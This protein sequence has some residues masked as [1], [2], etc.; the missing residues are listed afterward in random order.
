[1]KYYLI[2][3][4]LILGAC[5]Q[6]PWSYKPEDNAEYQGIY[7]E[8]TLIADRPIRDICFEKLLMLSE[9]YTDAYAFYSEASVIISG[10][11][12]DV[13]LSPQAQKPNCFEGDASDIVQRGSVYQLRATFTWDSSG[14]NVETTY[15]ATANVPTTF[16]VND[17]ATVSE[18][19]FINQSTNV[20]ASPEGLFELV[21]GLPQEGQDAFLNEYGD[22]IGQFTNQLAEG[23]TTGAMNLFFENFQEMN[24]RIGQLYEE[25]DV[26]APY[27]QGDSIYYLT[28]GLNTTSHY[29]NFQYSDDVASVLITQRFDTN[30]VVPLN[31]FSAAFEQFGLTAATQYFDGTIR[32]LIHY[33]NFYNPGKDF[34]I[35][36]SLPV[37]NTWYMG[38]NNTIYFYGYEQAFT[39]Y[40]LTYIDEHDNP[41]VRPEFNIEGGRGVFAGAVVDSFQVFIRNPDGNR[42][43]TMF[44]AQAGYCEEEGWDSSQACQEF[45]LRYCRQTS[46]DPVKYVEENKEEFDENKAYTNCMEAAFKAAWIDSVDEDTYVSLNPNFTQSDNA[47]NAASLRTEVR[48]QALIEFCVSDFFESDLCDTIEEHAHSWKSEIVQE[49]PEVNKIKDLH[50]MYCENSSWTA[51][52]CDWAQRSFCIEKD[53]SSTIL[54]EPAEIWCESQSDEIFCGKEP[55]S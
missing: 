6:G 49:H 13:V 40:A 29:Y 21:N 14:T 51:P 10:P 43:W 28:G 52:T 30:A 25:Y 46:F 15:R 24:A 37:T 42:S 4:A 36:D 2:I 7:T 53:I 41:K 17:T 5:I 23:D 33:P 20:Q 27:V 48:N 8:G 44:E 3:A 11:S 38:G 47:A 31:S 54:C 1:M 32:R 9:Y 12:G 18:Q 34:F 55:T 39:D 22:L 45:E 26:R 19:A 35:F 50:W 16:T